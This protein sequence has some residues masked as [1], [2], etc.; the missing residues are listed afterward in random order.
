MSNQARPSLED[1][2]RQRNATAPAH[3]QM[4][5]DGV[6]PAGPTGAA[7]SASASL[8]KGI[9]GGTIVGV[10]AAI[11]LTV[12]AGYLLNRKKEEPV[13]QWTSQV[14]AERARGRAMGGPDF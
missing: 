4:T 11:A 14:Q 10:A 8:P 12:G 1:V 6:R 5:I 13:G 9:K 2:I 3:L 7:K